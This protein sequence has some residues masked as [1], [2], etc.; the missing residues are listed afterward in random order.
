VP[1]PTS[2]QTAGPFF[3]FA[4]ERPEWSDLT[5]AGAKGEKIVVA[6]VVRDGDGAA[7]P[8]AL[9]EIRQADAHG[10]FDADPAF[11]GFG[12]CCTDPDGRFMFT[13][14]RPGAVVTAHGTQ[15]PHLALTIFARGL[16][17][18]LW[19]RVYFDDDAALHG[20][21]PLLASI[22]DP[23]QRAT[24]IAHRKP[25]AGAPAFFAF[26]IVLQGEG[27]TAFLAP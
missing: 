22:V 8:D 11:I 3:R 13:T 21:D 2:S 4:L 15:A 6:G 27:E 25:G 9:L 20:G 19:T 14:I 12:R 10:R 5:A 26:D 16:L 7:V 1:V 17:K 23:V 24:L 18:S